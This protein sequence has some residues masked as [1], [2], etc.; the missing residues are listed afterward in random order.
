MLAHQWTPTL[1][2]EVLPLCPGTRYVKGHTINPSLS[3]QIII[4]NSILANL[5]GLTKPDHNGATS[6][7]LD[8]KLID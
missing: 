7:T 6:G 8:I 5:V 3:I 1:I 4:I 2:V